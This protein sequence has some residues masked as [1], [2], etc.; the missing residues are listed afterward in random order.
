MSDHNICFLWR[1]K[2][3]I[4]IFRFKNVLFWIVTYEHMTHL[5]VKMGL[6]AY[7]TSVADL[8][9]VLRVQPNLPIQI[10]SFSWEII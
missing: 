6:M 9:G 3:N 5:Q 10:I 8:Q 2:K 7:A 1:N 4:T